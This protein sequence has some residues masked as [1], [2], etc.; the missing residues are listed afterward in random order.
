[1]LALRKGS[2]DLTVTEIHSR[3]DTRRVLAWVNAKRAELGLQPISYLP[4][5]TKKQ[6]GL[7]AIT[8][9]LSNKYID[10]RVANS[11][12]RGG[13][14][15]VVAKRYSRTSDNSRGKLVQQERY[16]LPHYAAEWSRKFDRGEFP[17]M[18]RS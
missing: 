17:A 15:I 1:M 14:Y 3:K 16:A 10:V 8:E 5:V 12:K 13:R 7:T 11:K 9:S 4:T 18:V 2:K 6:G